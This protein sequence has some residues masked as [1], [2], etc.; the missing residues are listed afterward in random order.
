MS[1]TSATEGHAERRSLRDFLTIWSGQAIS[2]LGSGLVQFSLVWWLTESTGS[3]IVLGLASMLALLPQVFLGPFAGALIDRWDRRKVMI[4]ADSVIALATVALAVLFRLGWVQIWH[5]CA[6]MFIRATGGAFHW[7]AMQASTPLM[8]PRQHLSRIAGLNQTLYG[9]NNIL[10]PPLGALLLQ[11]MPVEAV[12][13]IDVGTAVLAI[14]PL[15]LIPVP[16]PKRQVAARAADGPSAVLADLREGLRFVWTWRGL[17]IV[18]AMASILNLLVNPGFALLPILVT[19]HFHGGALQLA[20]LNSAWGVGMLLGGVVLGLWGG[21]RSCIVTAMLAL[22][23]QG[24]G[25]LV[26]GLTSASMFMPALG[27]LV[28]SGFMNPIVNGSFTAALQAVVPPEMQARVF[29]LVMSGAA[30][31]SPLGMVIAGPVADA[32]G[33]TVWFVIGGMATTLMAVSMFF[34]PA[35]MRIEQDG[36]GRPA[37]AAELSTY[38]DRALREADQ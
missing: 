3:A 22:A 28:F 11:V 35:V 17:A 20:W 12:L 30:A 19:D 24:L 5:V 33:V 6:L 21:L 26:I 14:A 1:E 29:T 4:V 38:S 25:L 16:Q 10:T 15:L 9:V 37:Q 13:A 2:L 8:V 36:A 18:L 32:F 27:A 34:V 7:P 23:L 31:M